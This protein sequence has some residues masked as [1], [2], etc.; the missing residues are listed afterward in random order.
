MM[1]IAVDAMGGDFAPEAPV[2]GAI[3]A[4]LSH[5]DCVICLIGDENL[6]KQFLPSRLPENLQLVHASQVIEMSEHPAKALPS[7]PDSSIAIGF[8]ML[9]RGKA[10]AFCSAGNSGAMLVGAMFSVKAIPGLLRPAIA[11]F[12]PKPSGKTGVILDIG[13]NAD[14]KPEFL[15]QFAELGSIYATEVLGIAKPKVGL[16]NIGEEEGKGTT[17]TQA[18]Y[19]ML[20]DNS[21]IDFVGNI[22]GRDVF[23]D[24][25]DVVVCDGF[26]GNIILKL[27]ESIY[28]LMV[29]EKVEIG[30]TFFK[31]LNYE[32]HGGSPVIGVNGNV[33]I[34]HGVSTPK[35]IEAMVYQ[36]YRMIKADISAKLAAALS[37]QL[38]EGN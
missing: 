19:T 34:G 7:K 35:A 10:Q 37:H 12:V 1:V 2:K 18:A 38:S 25:V 26:T 24:K 32:A 5:P 17:V 14:C 23:T 11:G 13:A 15:D 30:D 16:M 4:A 8:G 31:G 3:A 6:V 21:R 22:E 27:S 29:E 33:V 28:D 36:S 20:K 9:A